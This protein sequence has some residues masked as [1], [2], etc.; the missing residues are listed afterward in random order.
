M[1]GALPA[2]PSSGVLP[3]LQACAWLLFDHLPDGPKP[4]LQP[5]PSLGKVCQRVRSP[6]GRGQG[7]PAA[8]CRGG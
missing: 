3:E 8:G 4:T 6:P 5:R 7:G 1:S 2:S